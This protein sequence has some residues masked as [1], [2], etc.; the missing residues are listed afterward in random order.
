METVTCVSQRMS[1][2]VDPTMEAVFK[3]SPADQPTY[4]AG[5]EEV[6]A[7][8]QDDKIPQQ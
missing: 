1:A 5:S 7:V 2:M 8:F 3:K 6:D 4:V